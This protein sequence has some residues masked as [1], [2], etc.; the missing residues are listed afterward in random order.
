M[1]RTVHIGAAARPVAPY[2]EAAITKYIAKQIDALSNE[3]TQREIAL[4]IGY[5]KPTM[6]SMFKRGETRVPLDK[7]PALAKA[8]RVD[9]IYLFRLGLEQ[10]WPALGKTIED[11]FGR[12]ATA[13]EHE[14]FLAKWRKLTKDADPPPNARIRA[15]FDR[16]FEEVEALNPSG[17]GV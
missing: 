13:N 6:I 12:L 15:I 5:E 14:L 10:Y 17:D 1:R 16:A 9:P 7:I 8:L 4:E 2:A 3:K 11:A